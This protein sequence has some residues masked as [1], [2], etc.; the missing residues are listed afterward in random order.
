MARPVWS[1]PGT[2]ESVSQD[3]FTA[4]ELAVCFQQ[5]RLD[6]SSSARRRLGYRRRRSSAGC[7]QNAS[8]RQK[9]VF[10]AFPTSRTG[11]QAT[12][13][14]SRGAGKASPLIERRICS[15]SPK[16][17]MVHQKYSGLQRLSQARDV[18]GDRLQRS[19]IAAYEPTL[20]A[21]RLNS[22]LPNT[23]HNST[24]SLRIN[25]GATTPAATT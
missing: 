2:F 25:P 21:D 8:A 11:A 7:S 22:D 17:I 5:V 6:V 9:A 24:N 23:K 16:P 15:A 12:R 18:Q 10:V 3:S 20:Q 4:I 19:G 14:S 13:R 1:G